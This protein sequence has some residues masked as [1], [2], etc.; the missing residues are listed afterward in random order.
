M[1]LFG[2]NTCF[3]LLTLKP[4]AVQLLYVQ[5]SPN[6]RLKQLLALAKQHRIAVQSTSKKQLDQMVQGNHQGVVAQCQRLPSYN[7]N[8]L[9]DLLDA[10]QESSLSDLYLVLD[11][12]QDPHN[13]GAILRTANA[14][15][16]KAVIA[17]KDKSAAITETVRKVACGAA[18]LT[19]FIQVTNLA[20]AIKSMQEQGV[21]TVGLD[22]HASESLSQLKKAGS[23][24]GKLA[25]IMGNEGSGLRRL[26]KE[27]CDFLATIPMFGQVESLNVS[28]ATGIALAAIRGV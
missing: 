15:G 16:V 9:R 13:L 23:L 17:P 5:E 3:S 19:P 25:L 4:Q 14:M 21:W 28:V 18:E 12:V 6:A 8:D 27:H 24:K 10:E 20:R 22:A 7:E 2:L 11:Q 1:N 26:T